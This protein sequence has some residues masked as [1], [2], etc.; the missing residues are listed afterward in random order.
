[1]KLKS[2]PLS[3]NTE[4]LK[5]FKNQYVKIQKTIIKKHKNISFSEYEN[6]QPMF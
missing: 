3:K 5:S 2:K 6:T 4:F 1:M